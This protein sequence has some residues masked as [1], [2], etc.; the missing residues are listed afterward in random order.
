MTVGRHARLAWLLLFAAYVGASVL[1][2]TV[3]KIGNVAPIWPASGVAV[4]GVLLLG[5]RAAPVI[6]VADLTATWIGPPALSLPVASGTAL[7]NVLEA[8]VVAWI[9]ERL[10]FDLSLRRWRDVLLL[11]GASVI[12]ASL[13]ATLGVAV[14]AAAHEIGSVRLAWRSWAPSDM[15]GDIAVVSL[16]G[17]WHV[18][19]NWRRRRLDWLIGFPLLIAAALLAF[20]RQ[21]EVLYLLF[22]FLVWAPMR[23]G[24]HG[25][26]AAATIIGVVAIAQT[27]GGVGPFAEQDVV[28]GIVSLQVF[29][30]VLFI[31][32]LGFASLRYERGA[33]DAELRHRVLY[34]GLTDLPNRTLLSDRLH[35]ASGL[36]SR[37]G[38]PLAVLFLDFD[39]FRA[40]NDALGPHAGDEVLRTLADRLAGGLRA[41]DTLGRFGG[42]QFVV[43]RDDCDLHEAV[44][45]AEHLCDV[46]ETPVQLD[47]DEVCVGASIG[48]VHSNGSDPPEELLRNAGAAMARAKRRG[49]NSFE[50]HDSAA[51]ALVKSR[52]SMEAALRRALDRSQ[53]RLHFQP[54]VSTADGYID[55]FEALLRWEDP[56]KGLRP[57][58]E[59]IPLAEETGLI[60]AIGAWVMQEACR[61]LQSWPDSVGVSVNVSPVQIERGDLVSEISSALRDSA[62]DP[63]RVIVEITESALVRNVTP[64]LSQVRDLGVRIALDDFGVG[65]SSLGDVQ[66]FPLDIIKLDRRFI[67]ALRA[68]ARAEAIVDAVVRMAN[69]LELQSVAEGIETSEQLEVVSRL[70]YTFVQGFHLMR[71]V[72][73]DALGR[74]L[75]SASQGQDGTAPGL[76]ITMAQALLAGRGTGR[77][78]EDAVVGHDGQT[79][80]GGTAW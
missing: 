10:R 26:T 29:L 22:P 43:V 32:E 71:P 42:D 77:S 25:A 65:Y 75:R 72:D 4:A 57:P 24:R 19:P 20:S 54:I 23:L 62:C 67:S 2:E 38:T 35:Q 1:G 79:G 64:A 15:V 80:I 68:G 47:G 76:E 30:G 21:V 18:L 66:H 63:N 33:A 73:G 7:A 51:R 11:V 39:R 8:L 61:H 9:L 37:R 48:I 3:M 28:G 56:D 58:A 36:A 44:A 59:F 74:V 69:A 46:L 17:V 6:F 40:V 70:G 60:V 12:G 50:V 45:T 55:T 13:G 41:G 34:D 78:A 31:T 5:R 16:L 52:L 53:L 49:G 27:A 14:L